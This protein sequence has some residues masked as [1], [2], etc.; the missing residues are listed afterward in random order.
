MKSGLLVAS[1]K[2]LCALSGLGL[3]L[4]V[5]VFG[6]ATFTDSLLAS[7]VQPD[8]LSPVVGAGTQALR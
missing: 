7:V 4:V 2:H 6:Y 3:P 8:A 1:H 5:C